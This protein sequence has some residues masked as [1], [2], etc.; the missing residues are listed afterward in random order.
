MMKDEN[1]NRCY[2]LD[3][4]GIVLTD[5]TRRN[6]LAGETID[7]P[8]FK[9]LREG[10][11]NYV[12]NQN[13]ML[14]SGAIV[15]GVNNEVIGYVIIEYLRK[16]EREFVYNT[17]L[18]ILGISLLII[19]L[20]VINT[21]RLALKIATPIEELTK[22]I[23]NSVGGESVVLLS[24]SSNH[25]VALLTSAFNSMMETIKDSTVSIEE[26]KD[27]QKDLEISTALAQQRAKEIITQNEELK[28][29]QKQLVESEKLSS[30]GG[31]VAG[32]AH[33]INTPIGICVTASS[34]LRKLSKDFLKKYKISKLTKTDFEDFL[35]NIDSGHDLILSNMEKASSLISSFKKVAVDR[36]S[37]EL[38]KIN[39]KSYL[40]ELLLSLRYKIKKT[41]HKIL[42]EGDDFSEVTYPGIIS[43]IFTNLILNS[44]IHGFENIEMGEININ[45]AK[46]AD[47]ILITY[48]DN[49]CG[50]PKENIKKIFDP[51]FTTKRGRGGSGLGMN[52][53][54]NLVVSKLKGHIE[55]KSSENEF[56]EFTIKLPYIKDINNG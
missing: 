24:S 12:E 50:I 5:G 49:G 29:T 7:T 27:K 28:K 14:H 53:V 42:I 15:R 41:K 38:R 8:F 33:E 43:Q 56:T 51:F 3:S 47:Q 11:K 10:E 22:S 9:A 6:L 54:Y 40:N 25:Q 37:E 46:L 4:T 52:I 44:I 26:Y 45:L 34:H 55:C 32:V 21:L 2:A 13:G 48:T 39:F 30:L 16:S 23:Q 1:V 36:Q 18:W 19:V 20:A 17:L 35:S 31:L